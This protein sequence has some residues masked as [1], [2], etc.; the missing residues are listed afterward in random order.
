MRLG[1]AANRFREQK[2]QVALIVTNG[3]AIEIWNQ[4]A[5]TRQIKSYFPFLSQRIFSQCHFVAKHH[6][7]L[8]TT[9]KI[10]LQ[11]IFIYLHHPSPPAVPIYSLSPKPIA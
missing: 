6:K 4:E 9:F 2:Y 5:S 7:E 8:H 10:Q 11:S 3:S 1:I